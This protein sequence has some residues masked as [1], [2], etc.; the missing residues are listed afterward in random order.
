MPDPAVRPRFTK[1]RTPDPS[2][3]SLWVNASDDLLQHLRLSHQLH[4]PH[5][6]PRPL[7]P[8][9]PDRQPLL[10]EHGRHVRY[11][12]PPTP[13]AVAE[14]L[15]DEGRLR[16][17]H[18]VLRGAE[19]QF[20]IVAPLLVDAPDAERRPVVDGEVVPVARGREHVVDEVLLLGMV[21]ALGKVPPGH[22]DVV[23]D[24]AVLVQ[25]VEVQAGGAARIDL[26]SRAQGEGAED[27]GEGAADEGPE[28]RRGVVLVLEVRGGGEDLADGDADAEFFHGGSQL[29]G[30]DV[31]AVAGDVAVVRE[32]V[33]DGAGTA[34]VAW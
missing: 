33:D 8:P 1:R 22:G 2:R 4:E 19:G 20:R 27:V 5:G 24:S 15:L 32:G 17:P 28:A 7:P 29:G 12:D 10:A 16:E 18:R 26:S 11:G 6:P 13:G 25:L 21:V 30:A 31:A 3:R 34:D 9:F 14:R 23:L